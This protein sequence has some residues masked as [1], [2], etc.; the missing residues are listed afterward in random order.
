MKT[1]EIY[2]IYG[3]DYKENTV[4][5]LKESNLKGEILEKCKFRPKEDIRIG[6]KPNLVTPTPAD[7]GATTHPEVVE[8]IIEYLKG[9]GF[10][11]ITIMEGSWIGDKTEVAFDVCGYNS[12]AAKY[13]AKI[14]DAQKDGYHEVVDGNEKILVCNCLDSVD[15]MINVPVLKGHCQT[16]ITCAIKNMKG[17]IPNKE[18]RSFHSRGLHNPIGH[19]AHIAK[20]DFIVIDHICGDLDFEEGGNPVVKN[21]IMTA[22]D[23]VLVDSYVCKLLG[24]KVSDVPYVKLAGDLGVGSTDIENADIFVIGKNTEDSFENILKQKIINDESFD[25]R[26]RVLD[27]AYAV[28]DVDSCSACYASLI[29]AL[30]R[31]KE[32][33][34]LEKLKDKIAIGQGHR[35]KTGKI[36]VGNCTSEFD[37]CIKGCPP[38]EDDVYKA[39]KEYIC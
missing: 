14:V 32:E 35:G 18:K 37:F 30:D 4:C 16:K 34:L 3:I 38:H 10:D 39:L 22:K 9:N 17:L 29:P 6:I 11:N 31:L 19:L 12:L 28:E 2:K 15:F 26:S 24:Y 8:G 7:Y 36:G 25:K 21:C 20:Q 5:L 33:G 23:P 1:N 13:N 27:V